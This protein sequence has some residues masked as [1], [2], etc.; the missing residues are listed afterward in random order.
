MLN[1][2]IDQLIFIGFKADNSLRQ[3]LDLLSDTDRKYVSADDSAFLRICRVGDDVY[4]GKIVRDSLTTDQVDDIRR[5]VLSIVRKLGP[6]V[7]LPGH[8]KIV[9][10][11][12][13]DADSLL[14]ASQSASP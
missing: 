11:S 12:E 10:C 8:L 14:T 2:L 6:L 9:A 7:R 5:N 3:R 4:V 1:L 13:V